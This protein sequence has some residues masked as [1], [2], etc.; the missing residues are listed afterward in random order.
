LE[1]IE[2]EFGVEVKD[3]EGVVIAE[4]KKVVHLRRRGGEEYKS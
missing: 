2:R 3:G 4:V 1:K